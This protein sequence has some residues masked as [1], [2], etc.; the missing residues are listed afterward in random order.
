[1]KYDIII[2]GGGPAGLM[3]ACRASELGAKVLLLEKNNQLGIKLLTT[4]GGRCNITNYIENYK[5]LAN[6]YGKN[7]RFL[8]SAF[9][10]FGAK[11]IVIFFEN[12]GIKT[13]IEKNNQIFPI[14]NKAKEVLNSL[15]N[16][17]TKHSGEIITGV[18]VE[19]IITQN[20]KIEKIILSDKKE[21]TA[22]NY[23]ISTGGKSYPL[24]GSTGDA[25]QWLH[26][27]GHNI[28][29][30]KPGLAP[31]IVREKYVKNLEGLSLSSIRLSLFEEN[32][33]IV[34]IN[35]DIIF[36]ANGISGPAALN[37]S[38]YVSQASKDSI[39]ILD[40]FPDFT[41]DEFDKK[42]QQL[43]KE[44]SQKDFKN[45]LIG[46]L[47]PKLIP[48]IISLG[49]FKDNKK[50]NSITKDERN[51]L[52][53]LLKNLEL[54]I[55]NVAS[56]DKAMITVGGLDLKE[57][58]PKTMRS[59]L[60]SNLFVAGELLDLNGPTGGYNLQICW[61]TGYVAGSSAALN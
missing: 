16:Y 7:G 15:I 29:K 50:T 44:N 11:E 31:I 27:M 21:L 13:K 6:S 4:G 26:N 57:V 34:E 19:K 17:I 42:L 14:N 12:L 56:Y 36:T 54:N 30:Q 25:Y 38:S 20:G 5:D 39:I 49:N 53:N 28:I 52:L 61:S 23:I 9:S 10:K 35:G 3:A 48:E 45:I 55:L 58:D 40:I 2:I 18:K 46:I 51:T 43:F 24:T 32:K 22:Y 59:K 1:M 37:L 60:I 33:K 47:Q 41:K 8:L